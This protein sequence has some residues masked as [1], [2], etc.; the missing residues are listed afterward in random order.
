MRK[1]PEVLRISQWLETPTGH[2]VAYG[3]V[4]IS[5]VGGIALDL[6]NQSEVAVRV[7]A[8]GII[9]LCVGIPVVYWVCGR[10]LLRGIEESLRLQRHV[11]VARASREAGEEGPKGRSAAEEEL[12]SARRRVKGMVIYSF[13]SCAKVVV[14]LLF[15]VSSKYGIENPLLF[16]ATPM[17]LVPSVWNAINIQCHARRTKLGSEWL[18]SGGSLNSGQP[19]MARLSSTA[20]RLSGTGRISYT[21]KRFSG[22]ARWQPRNQENQ[23][24]PTELPGVMPC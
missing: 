2:V 23:V 9:V 10:S 1:S 12:F 20:R 16:F 14:I 17:A 15:A 5:P 24:V 6:V 8:A 11:Q 7:I 18:L 3:L 19:F 22:I 4:S 13:L 21:A